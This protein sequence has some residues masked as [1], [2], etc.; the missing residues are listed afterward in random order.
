MNKTIG[1]ILM[2]VLS[3][4][5]I[6][7]FINMSSDYDKV[8]LTEEFVTV[9]NTVNEEELIV[10]Q[11][12]YEIL[13]V[14]ING[15]HMVVEDVVASIHTNGVNSLMLVAN[16]TGIGDDVIITYNYQEE[17]AQYTS[18]FIDAVPIIMIIIVLSGF[19][20]IVIRRS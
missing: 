12:I 7:M 14:H 18:V 20:Y 1:V 6:L 3:I 4:F 17:S 2:L 10:H 19:A 13:D 11:P 8:I 9:E 16:T 15:Y 5:L